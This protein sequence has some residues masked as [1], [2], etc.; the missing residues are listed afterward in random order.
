MA[1]GT[2]VRPRLFE[3]DLPKD[4][5]K[6][7]RHPFDAVPYTPPDRI[8]DE[9]SLLR[10][11]MAAPDQVLWWP[12]NSANRL[13]AERMAAHGWLD[14]D[15]A[16]GF[17]PSDDGAAA[18]R[19]LD[20]GPRP[21]GIA[22]WARCSSLRDACTRCERKRRPRALG[23]YPLRPP[24]QAGRAHPI[25]AGATVEYRRPRPRK[26]RP[27]RRHQGKEVVDMLNDDQLFEDYGIE[28]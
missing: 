20:A 14:G 13:L 26:R 15:A 18:I 11:L 2:Q 19:A 3:A 16:R 7:I 21:T 22:R 1:E 25:R 28:V 9:E 24:W 27:L 5:R 12:R 10:R 6:P 17:T 8:L 23:P 4:P